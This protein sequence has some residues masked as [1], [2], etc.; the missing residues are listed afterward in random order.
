MASNQSTV[1]R[2]TFHLP[3]EITIEILSRL[4]VKS[5]LRFKSVCKT[6]YDL[7]KTHYFIS[8]H[9]QTQ[10]TLNSTSLLVTTYN[11]K[12]KNHAVSLVS[13]D[14]PIILDFPFLKRRKFTLRSREY[15]GKSYFSIVGICN[16]LVCMNLTPFGYPLVLCNPS[17]RQFRELPSSEWQH[18]NG[19]V[20]VKRV[21]F[22]FGFHASANDYKLIRIVLYSSRME[23]A[24]IQADLYV[25]RT[26]TWRKIDA[27]KASVFLGEKNKLG[28]FGSYVQISGSCASAVLN[29]VFYWPACVVSTN[30]GTVMSFDMA[31][32]VFRRI[33]MPVCL[34]KTWVET[35]WWITE[36]KDKLALFIHPDDRCFD[37]WVLNEDQSSWTNQ[38]KIECFPMIERYMGFNE[39]TVVGG[40]KDGELV[41][42][43]HEVSGGLKLFSYDLKTR[44]TMDLYFGHVPYPSDIY[45][46][47]GTLLP[48]PVMETNEIVLN[49]KNK[50]RK[51]WWN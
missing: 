8:K 48:L 50:K 34:D 37:V 17:T 11:G 36:L 5:L 21:S 47:T 40:A 42:T 22:G 43:D 16:G 6:W 31:D 12:T 32:E 23:E 26:G 44:E 7:I 14:G 35:N 13:N 2:A 9:L 41:V 27:D 28:W 49:K 19:H 39:I 4:P 10:S 3:F 45:L 1:A 46:Y 33:R 15:S 25:M 24:S 18:Y 29:G 30:E 20:R 51:H 38:F